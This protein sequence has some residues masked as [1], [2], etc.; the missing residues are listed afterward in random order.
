MNKPNVILLTI[1]T[2]RADRLGC[3]GYERPLTPNL[4]RLA[5]QGVRFAQAITGGSWTQAAFP[6]MMTSTY[7]SMFGGCLGALAGERPSPLASFVQNGYTT[8]GFSTSPLLSRAYGY[9]RDFHYFL[10]IEPAE[11]DPLLFKIK[12]GQRLL[13]MP[14]THAIS[15]WL[16]IQTR[17]A[18]TYVTAEKLTDNA[19]EWLAQVQDEPFFAWL[20]YM[21]VHWPYHQEETLKDPVK[22]AQ[23]WRDRAHLHR[24]AFGRETITPEQRE[25]YIRLYEEAIAYTDAQVGRLLDYLED[26]G[27]AEN[28]IIVVVSDHGEEFLEHGRWGHFENNLHDEILIVPL[29]IKLPGNEGGRVVTRQVRLLDLMPTLLELCRCPLPENTA[30]VSMSPLW[31]GNEAEYQPTV[32]I[33][34]MWRDHWHI[35]AI[36]TQSFKYIWDSQTPEDP[37]LF[38][39]RIDPGE[40][41]NVIAK[42]PE[43]IQELQV[44]I[45]ERLQQMN[46]TR[47]VETIA[48]PELDDEMMSRLRGLGY[49][50]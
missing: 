32:S 23:A 27:L 12:G 20:H 40:T 4:D 45:E 6:V 29:I 7:A 33:S 5:E 44:F 37:E 22:I 15:R 42:F 46:E 39:L 41:N 8:G 11:S 16:G 24:V 25:Y 36:R 18:Q 34:E 3:Y 28:T 49:L 38:D 26:T 48:E 1:D 31:T 21:D 47:P 17:P 19:F 43:L 50:E 35:I 13:R 10:D 2:L 14:I 9:N 30:G